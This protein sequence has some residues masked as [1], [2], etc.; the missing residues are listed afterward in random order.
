MAC[1]CK[2]NWPSM[3]QSHLKNSK[4]FLAGIEAF[5]NENN[6]VVIIL[7][8]RR[9]REYLV[10]KATNLNPS[11]LCITCPSWDHTLTTLSNAPDKTL[12]KYMELTLLDKI[13]AT[14]WFSIV[15]LNSNYT[16]YRQFTY[17]QQC[18]NMWNLGTSYSTLLNFHMT[19]C[20]QNCLPSKVRI[21]AGG[22]FVLSVIR[23][24]NLINL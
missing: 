9:W 3:P 21:I 20:S 1:C 23:S 11:N 19:S 13:Q 12:Q 15:C 7:I 16:L 24:M 14:N 5:N 17:A 10:L 4:E 8:P 6:N 2:V 18:M 22:H